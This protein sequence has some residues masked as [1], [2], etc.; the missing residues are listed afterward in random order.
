MNE[1]PNSNRLLRRAAYAG[2]GITA[3]SIALTAGLI[4]GVTHTAAAAN[5]SGTSTTGTST[6]TT[7]TG[8]DTSGT[9]TTSNSSTSNS[10]G[11]TSSQ[12]GSTTVS[13]S[14]GS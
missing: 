1:Q 4:V 2:A 9:S 10:S 12:Q 5:Q 3:A 14:H 6:T 8:T 13:G 7:N 11:I